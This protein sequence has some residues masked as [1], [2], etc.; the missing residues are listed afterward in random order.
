MRPMKKSSGK[1]FYSL[2]YLNPQREYSRLK[3]LSPVIS[4]KIAR[5]PGNT[6]TKFRQFPFVDGQSAISRILGGTR[7]TNCLSNCCAPLVCVS[8]VM[9]LLAVWRHNKPKTKAVK[10]CF[11]LFFPPYIA[12]SNEGTGLGQITWRIV[13]GLN[14]FT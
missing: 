10:F 14:V 11:F 3:Y 4:V 8:A 5:L 2:L 1:M 9:E 6:V 12:T 7:Q 13:T